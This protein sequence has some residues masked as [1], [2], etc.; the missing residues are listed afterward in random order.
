MNVGTPHYRGFM[1][2]YAGR[3]AHAAEAGTIAGCAKN[4]LSSARK[5]GPETVIVV[6]GGYRDELTVELYIMPNDAY[7]PLLMP[8]VS[9]KKVE[10]LEGRYAYCSIPE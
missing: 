7:P 10:I 2:V 5:V 9:P 4:Y 1:L 8:T 6:D 3:S